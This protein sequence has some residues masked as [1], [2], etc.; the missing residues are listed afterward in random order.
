MP[1]LIP[2][3]SFLI[4]FLSQISCAEQTQTSIPLRFDFGNP[5]PYGG[6]S[7]VIT[8]QGK[9]IPLLLDTGAKKSELSL[10]PHALTNLNVKFTSE[11]ECFKTIDGEYCEQTFIIPEIKLGSF[12]IKN[13]K[14]TMMSKLW[15]GND[16]D[17]K[18][19]EASRNGVIG[20]AL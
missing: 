7:T 14:G 3:I 17:F 19:N 8:I 4:I 13:V 6:A 10:S 9:E 11:Y 16:E 15:G 5:A 18:E 12:V 1:M 20:F 2:I